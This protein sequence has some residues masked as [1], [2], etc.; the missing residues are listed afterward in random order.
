LI[1]RAAAAA[2]AIVATAS[3]QISAG[4]Y[5]PQS[6][7]APAPVGLQ[8]PYAMR[9]QG[10]YVEGGNFVI[11]NASTPVTAALYAGNGSAIAGTL[12][13]VVPAPPP[14]EPLLAVASYD[15]GVV[16]HDAD[17]LRE[18]GTMGIAGHPTSVSF[19]PDGMLAAADTS[20]DTLSLVATQAWA[21]KRIDNVLLAD[22]VVV[23]PQTDTVF[24]SDR[25]VD[26]KGALTRVTDDGTVTRITTG[27]TAEGLALDDRRG[28]VYVGNVNDGTVLAVDARTMKPIRRIKTVP[29]VFGIAISPDGNTLYAVANQSAQSQFQ[30]AGYVAAFDLRK[31]GAPRIAHSANLEFPIGVAL[32]RHLNRLF[33]TDEAGNR[34]Y[35]LDARTLR[36]A[37]ASLSTCK[38]P[39]NPDL[40]SNGRLLIP[41]AGSNQI[42]AFDART[43]R[44]IAGAP[45][46][47]G[48]YPLGVSVWRPMPRG[49]R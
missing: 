31:G 5:F 16:L 39:W 46:T 24:A 45:F 37:H 40:D 27:D 13:N 42:D 48:G 1:L 34:V 12:V 32:D 35:V 47:T 17:T 41:C 18:L 26:G 21:V 10:A 15:D 43:L 29:R 9:A 2:C 14:G 33:V 7:L 6:R 25:S 49:E 36:P 20:G 28:I 4:P 44:R 30:A 8:P 19:A 3:L 23:D 22:E 38:I 11:G